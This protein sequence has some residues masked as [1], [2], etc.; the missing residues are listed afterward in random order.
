MKKLIKIV[1][2]AAALLSCMPL[3]AADTPQKT[4]MRSA[5]VATVW[6][7]DWPPSVVSSTGNTSQI[8]KQK[9]EMLR[10]LDSLHV[11][12]MN[13][14]NFQVRSRCDAFYKSSYEPWSS[15]L[16]SSRGLDPG[17]DPL[18]FVVE[19]CHKR[20]MECHAWLNPYR[21]ESVTNQWSGQPGDYRKDHPDWIMDVNNASILNPGK[22][23]VTQRI[24]DI[25]A[26]IVKNYDID[27]VLFDDYFYLSGTTAAMDADLYNAYKSGGGKLSQNDWRRD[28]V[29]RMIAAVYKTIKDIKPYVRFGV[30]PAGIA[31]TSSSVAKNYGISPCPTG[32]DW[33]YSDI[34]SDPIAWVSQQS[35]DF[36]S[37][38]IYWTIGNSTDYDKAC[39]WWSDVAHK[40][41]R[42]FYSSHS[43]SSLTSSSKS[44]GISGIEADKVDPLASGPNSDS[45]SEYAAEIRL[46][47]KY[48]GDNAPGS[49]FYSCKYLYNVAPKFAHYLKTT[50]FNTPALIP[51]MPWFPVSDP[52][53]VTKLTRAGN[54]LSWTG[55]D[56]VRYSVYA[57]PEKIA[58]ENFSRDVEYLLGVTYTNSYTLP[59]KYLTGYNFAVCVY[60]RYGNEYSPVFVGAAQG[61]LAAPT[62]TSPT[63]GQTIEMPFDFTWKSVANAVNYVIEISD[64]QDMS[65]LLYVK[66]V[67]GTT[68]NTAEFYKMPIDKVLYW[69]V[70]ACGNN[71]EDGVSAVYKFTARNLQFT[72][73]AEAQTDVSLTPTFKWSITD[74]AV[75]IQI[76]LADDF[77][78]KNL[79]YQADANGGSYAMPKYKLAYSTTYYARLLYSRNGVDCVSPVVS[80]TTLA[81]VPDVPTVKYP[82]ANGTL[83]ADEV[84]AI[85]PIEGAKTL[86]IEVNASTSFSSRSSYVQSNVDMGAFADTKTGSQIT[87]SS[88]GLTDGGTYYVR[89]RAG[90]VNEEG[91]SKNTDFSDPVK[92][93]YSAQ[94]GGVDAITVDSED[95]KTPAQIYDLNGRPVENAAPGLYIQRKGTKA[96]K[97]IVK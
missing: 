66:S 71:Y 3:Q 19:E 13:A 28:N 29:N 84:I 16:V 1:A 22:Q 46:N 48:N 57:V 4:E 69:R 30:S 54:K 12:N 77:E 94:N 31:C 17:Y 93:T 15:D 20:G 37:P 82:V 92:F 75:K 36:I 40:W 95:G 87:I 26:E 73:P 34:F 61:T 62:L 45:F 32:S 6:R 27:G 81:G 58:K 51:S 60:D 43:I 63:N 2:A 18:A 38:Q 8:K 44:P 49:I 33:Q 67:D 47:R 96:T 64:K 5:W 65:S 79:V 23:E 50:V 88:K 97:V 70:R 68:V 7:L 78:D 59:D 11:N 21:F 55:R 35:L 25:I 86:R 74:R 53:K 72:Y 76:A 42:H 39:K 85:N 89:V 9:D 52:G 41:N 56:N 80:F 24:C 91:S 90:Y 83:H 10:L 14:I